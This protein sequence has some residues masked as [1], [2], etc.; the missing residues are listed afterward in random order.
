MRKGV[1]GVSIFGNKCKNCGHW[2]KDRMGDHCD[3]PQGCPVDGKKN[4]DRVDEEIRRQLKGSKQKG[5]DI[6]W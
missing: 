4:R 3:N 5:L 2:K 6:H 1:L